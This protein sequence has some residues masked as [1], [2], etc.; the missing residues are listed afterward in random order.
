[1]LN[2]YKVPFVF[3]VTYLFFHILLCCVRNSGGVAVKLL[4]SGARGPWFD[5]RCHRYFS[6][7]GYLLLQ[8][9]ILLK[10]R[11]SDVNRHKKRPTNNELYYVW[12]SVC[13]SIGSNL[14]PMYLRDVPLIRQYRQVLWDQ[15]VLVDLVGHFPPLHHLVQVGPAL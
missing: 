12:S 13:L 1:M 14:F 10:Y 11:W 3:V 6:E 2:V 5:S 9:A 8:V 7:I 15:Q 4:A